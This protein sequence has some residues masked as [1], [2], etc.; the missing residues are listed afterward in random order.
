[1]KN[2]WFAFTKYVWKFVAA[3][4]SDTKQNGEVAV[5]LGRV[6]FLSVLLFMFFMWYKSFSGP[7]EEPPGL[8]EVFYTL[9]GY[10]F[11][12]KALEFIREKFGGGS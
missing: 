5:S 3:L 1:M 12:T 4:I 11:G 9:A 7:I 8:M 2:I 6:C 10:V